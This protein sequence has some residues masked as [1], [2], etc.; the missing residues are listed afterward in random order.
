M[1]WLRRG[2]IGIAVLGLLVAQA[3][4]AKSVA[5]ARTA[6]S[7][8][9]EQ[10]RVAGAAESEAQHAFGTAGVALE[11]ARRGATTRRDQSVKA[12]AAVRSA[13][14]TLATATKKLGVSQWMQAAG[15]D[16][17]AARRRCA[18]GVNAA[19]TG[20]DTK[21]VGG[22][23][24]VLD[25]VL[26]QC[27]QALSN[28]LSKPPVFPFDF[29]DPSVL[30]VD[31]TYYAYSTNAT[32]GNMQVISS[33]DLRHWHLAGDALPKLAEWALP[34]A[35][36][37]P[38]VIGHNGAYLA[39]YT[40]RGKGIPAQCISV[41]V[42]FAPTGPFFDMSKNPLVCDVPAGGSIDPSPFVDATGDLWLLWKNEGLQAPPTIWSIRL[43][44][45]GLRPAALPTRLLTASAGGWE[46]RAIE[47]PTMFASPGGY[48][49]L[50]SANSWST[51]DY[52][53]GAAHCATPA[54]PCTKQT[55]PVLTTHE[56]VVGPGG[57]AFFTN[58]DGLPYVAYAAYAGANVG[59]PWSR[60]LHIA[61]VTF[62]PTG[63]AFGE[64]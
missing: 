24:F 54:G 47:G 39:Y 13:Q 40:V 42:A 31:D 46:R 59:Y 63:I 1:R 36:W 64:E 2:A 22:A 26:P 3:A 37:A 55:A 12:A 5:D 33:T 60:L 10:Y 9:R 50:Y 25:A 41:A 27:M 35:T 48:T 58:A 62:T 44:E 20:I 8:A 14:K 43:D 29:A 23:T 61:P 28:A 45:T 11:A 19:V 38:A 21:N 34:G 49:L 7:A 53:I 56:D 4:F 51:A 32:A 30:R 15:A 17:I 18:D 52:G 6:T 57:P 16:Q